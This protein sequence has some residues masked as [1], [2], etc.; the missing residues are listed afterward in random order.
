MKVS[1]F[2][3]FALLTRSTPL[4]I[5]LQIH[6]SNAK[7]SSLGGE[8]V[9]GESAVGA[10]RPHPLFSLLVCAMVERLK[11]FCKYCCLRLQLEWCI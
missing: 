11:F 10:K 9:G 5:K 6:E 7:I 2:Y 4:L 1:F 8:T 3:L